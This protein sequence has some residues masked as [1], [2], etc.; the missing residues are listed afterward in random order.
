LVGLVGREPLIVLG[1]AAQ[2][3]SMDAPAISLPVWSAARSHRRGSLHP[4]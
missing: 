3:A 1:A 4:W 2:A